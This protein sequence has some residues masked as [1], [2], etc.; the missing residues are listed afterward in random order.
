MF[1]SNPGH[2]EGVKDWIETWIETCFE[3]WT[4]PMCPS[5]EISTEPNLLTVTL[6]VQ[7]YHHR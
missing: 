1:Q 6:I 3:T 7:K 4:P 5:C 2:M